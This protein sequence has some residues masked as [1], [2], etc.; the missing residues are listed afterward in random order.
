[1]PWT[2]CGYIPQLCT[3]PV[4][5]V[6]FLKNLKKNTFFAVFSRW[7]KAKRIPNRIKYCGENYFPKNIARRF[8]YDG[9]S[10]ACG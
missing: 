7:T 9:K 1:M 2:G 10:G 5:T 3:S 4:K 6:P 8:A